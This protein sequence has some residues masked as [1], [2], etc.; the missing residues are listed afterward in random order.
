M[1][2]HRRK[3][4]ALTTPYVM[5]APGYV[6]VLMWSVFGGTAPATARDSCYPC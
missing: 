5:T 1:G 4:M 3:V 6:K 2:V